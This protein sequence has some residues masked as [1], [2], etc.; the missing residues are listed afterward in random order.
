MMTRQ[1]IWVV[2][3]ANSSSH[4]TSSISSHVVFH[5][6]FSTRPWHG[7]SYLRWPSVHLSNQSY[8]VEIAVTQLSINNV[9]M[10]WVDGWFISIWSHYTNLWCRYHFGVEY[11]PHKSI[12]PVKILH[13]MFN[14]PKHK[15]SK[16]LLS[17]NMNHCF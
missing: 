9:N 15:S 10:R 5:V 2:W 16:M 6:T 4:N 3:M 7:W 1:L 14:F 17:I 8:N 11:V 12:H 13:C